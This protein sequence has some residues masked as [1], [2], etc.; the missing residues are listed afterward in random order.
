MKTS[1]WKSVWAVAAGFLSVAILST[2]VDA[3]LHGTGVFPPMGKPMSDSLFGLATSYRAIFQV[4][5]G[6]ITARL[7]PARGMKHVWI[8]AC[9]GFAMSMV[10]VLVWKMMGPEGGPLWY[11]LALVVLAVPTVWCG[12]RLGSRS[13]QHS[14][15]Q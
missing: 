1:I 6:F 5:G 11:P 15:G 10:G 3:I 14:D 13:E 4:L 8:L 2:A 9:I 7:A 12:G